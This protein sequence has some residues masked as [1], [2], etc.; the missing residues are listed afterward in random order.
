VQLSPTSAPLCVSELLRLTLQLARTAVM[1]TADMTVEK[2]LPV[3]RIIRTPEN[4][5][6]GLDRA[7]DCNLLAS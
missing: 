3:L 7:F 1:E 6:N 5:P 2:N 4:E